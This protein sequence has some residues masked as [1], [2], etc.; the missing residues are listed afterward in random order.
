MSPL[1]SSRILTLSFLMSLVV[2]AMVAFLAAPDME[3]AEIA[4]LGPAMVGVAAMTA[5]A[6]PFMR[7][8]VM[9]HH[10][11]TPVDELALPGGPRVPPEQAAQQWRAAQARYQVGTIVGL[12]LAEAVAIY[13]LVVALLSA[14]G[15]RSVPYLVAGAVLILAQFPREACAKQL[16]SPGAR[17]ALRRG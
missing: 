4:G 9:G 5:L 7:K 6:I 12:A 10:A 8:V 2:Y 11:L 1:M 3:P 15:A 13:G 14:E 16:L 17:A